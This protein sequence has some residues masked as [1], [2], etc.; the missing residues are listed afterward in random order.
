MDFLEIIMFSIFG[1][2][3]FQIY[4]RKK[5][6]LKSKFTFTTLLLIACFAF[7]SLLFSDPNS[8]RHIKWALITPFLFYLI[9]Y[10]FTQISIKLQ[11]R[12]FH[13][14]LR[15]SNEISELTFKDG[16]HIKWSDKI[17]SFSL[18]IICI[19]LMISV[20]YLK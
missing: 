14:W 1:F 18:L 13:L 4:Q 3:F 12:D 11:N 16:S 9:N 20:S 8:N 6:W 17:L 7:T 19:L 5:A 10:S 2:N 15:G